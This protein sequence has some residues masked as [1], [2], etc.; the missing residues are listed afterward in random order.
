MAGTAAD[1]IDTLP[2]SADEKK[3]VRITVACGDCATLP[4]VAAAGETFDG[5]DGRYQVMHNGLKVVEGGYYGRWMTEIIRILRGHHEPQ[6]ERVFAELLTHVPPGAAMLELGAFWAYYSV[7]FHRAIPRA[8]NVMVEPD[9]NNLAIGK[10]NFA[11]NGYDGEFINALVGRESLPAA[12]FRCESDG[13]VRPLPQ[14]SVDDY[15]ARSSL[16]RLDLVLADI[17]GAEVEMLHGAAES[18]RKGRIRFMVIS[19]HHHAISGDPLTHL[20]CLKFLTDRNAHILAAHN[21]FESFSGDGL[22]V[23]SFLPEDRGLPPIPISRNDPAKGLFREI[24]YDLAEAWQQLA[25]ARRNALRN[26]LR[27][28]I[29]L[30]PR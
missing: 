15:M 6:E 3:R 30:K 5:P 28:L 2:I 24:E 19:T 13:V 4:K 17:Q 7:W 14:F 27:R 23:A 8:K 10:K 21:V 22:I 9:P 29:G 25:D 16:P 12:P 11:L 26:R 18:I 20:N 1:H